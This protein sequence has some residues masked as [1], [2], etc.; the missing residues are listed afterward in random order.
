MLEQ[1]LQKPQMGLAQMG[2]S[3]VKPVL[4][5]G[6]GDRVERALTVDKGFLASTGVS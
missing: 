6:K 1:V 3:M 5:V 2:P 4:L